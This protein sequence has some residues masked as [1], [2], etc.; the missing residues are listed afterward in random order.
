MCGTPH[1]LEPLDDALALLPLAVALGIA[2]RNVFQF[3][4]EGLGKFFDVD[5]AQHFA[6]G[7]RADADAE[8]PTVL[9]VLML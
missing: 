2:R 6:H 5:L 9:L 8:F 3:L 4:L 1:D 7:L